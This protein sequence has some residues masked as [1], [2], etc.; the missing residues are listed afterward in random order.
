MLFL[1]CV[2]LTLHSHIEVGYLKLWGYL[3]W[4]CGSDAGCKVGPRDPLF[5]HQ[6]SACPPQQTIQSSPCCVPC[7]CIPCSSRPLA[8]PDHKWHYFTFLRLCGP[9]VKQQSQAE[10]PPEGIWT[11][12]AVYLGTEILFACNKKHYLLLPP[13]K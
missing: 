12:S 5:Q 10:T 13:I 9:V 4:C 3:H 11:I 6:P 1:P 2:V 7:H 8:F